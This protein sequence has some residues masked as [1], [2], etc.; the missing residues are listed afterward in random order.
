M[1]YAPPSHQD[2]DSRMSVSAIRQISVASENDGLR[3]EIRLKWRSR[4]EVYPVVE[5]VQ[6]GG[7]D[8]QAKRLR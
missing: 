1:S 5:L 6:I 7:V 2:I 8:R 3:I 4:N